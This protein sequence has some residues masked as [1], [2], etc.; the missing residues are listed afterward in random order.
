MKLNK[1]NSLHN[2]SGFT[3]AEVLIT[4]VIIGVIAALTIPTAI[5]NTKEQELKSQFAKAYSTVSQALYK[6][7]MNNFYGYAKCYYGQNGLSTEI[8][9]CNKFFN[10]LFSQ[11][12]SVQK[13]CTNNSLSNGCIPAYRTYAT[14]GG[15]SGFNQGNIENTNSSYVLS[16]G[17]IIIRYPWSMPDFLI[18]IN[19]HKGPN[20][21]GKDLFGFQLKRNENTGIFL[22]SCGTCGFEIK[23]NA[24][25][26]DQ[27]ML[28]A[29]AGKK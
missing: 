22:D 10:T 3:L 5:N 26:T 20:V 21:Y 25:T 24:R 29:L 8:S 4:L 23:D 19:G 13:I 16:D 27:M 18:D 6:T 14:S 11:T 12:L 1:Y 17:Q 9:E 7:E 2:K 15:W 28:Y